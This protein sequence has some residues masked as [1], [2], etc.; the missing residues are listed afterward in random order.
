MADTTPPMMRGTCPRCEQVSTTFDVVGTAML[1]SRLFESQLRCRSCGKSSLAQLYNTQTTSP[2]NS[3]RGQYIDNC[4]RFDEWVLIVPDA[5]GCPDHVPEE[6][7]KLFQEGS[8][9]EAHQL[10]NAAGVMYRKVLDAA[11]RSKTPL[12]VE[13]DDSTPKW[14]VYKDLRLRLD[15]LFERNL[16][17][18]S[19][20]D[21]SSCIHQDGNDAA[22]STEGI[23]AEEA[24]DIGD[25]VTMVLSAIYTIPGQIQANIKRREERRGAG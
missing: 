19:L 2:P 1:G 6:I 20:K 12:P 9:C 7:V 15:W 22:H 10:W 23:G 8:T 18:T 24:Q 14:K 16:L 17:D 25:F 13:K 11:T 5:R 21:L 3:M 4:F